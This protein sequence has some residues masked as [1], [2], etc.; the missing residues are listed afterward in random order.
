MDFSN[1]YDLSV[2]F[3]QLRRSTNIDGLPTPAAT[4]RDSH[5]QLSSPGPGPSSSSSR[6]PFA[7]PSPPLPVDP[8]AS[9]PPL[10]NAYPL[11]SSSSPAG[12]FQTVNVSPR[13]YSND[14]RA[15]RSPPPANP[16]LQRQM[17]ESPTSYGNN[18]NEYTEGFRL[19]PPSP[20]SS[21][22]QPQ[23]VDTQQREAAPSPASEQD[24]RPSWDNRQW[25]RD[26]R[27][28]QPDAGTPPRREMQ[29][30]P[31][32]NQTK[33]STGPS[34]R[35]RDDAQWAKSWRSP[36]EQVWP[37]PAPPRARAEV[38]V[39]GS[40][41]APAQQPTV[42]AAPPPVQQQQAQPQVEEVCVECAM[43]DEDMADVDVTSP[44]VWAR[45]SDV[46]FEDLLQK[47][48]AE[49]EAGIVSG[50]PSRPRARGGRLTEANLRLWLTLVR[51]P[52]FLGLRSV[53]DGAAQ[54][55][56]EPTSKRANL[57]AYVRSQYAL[58]EA[59]AIA[60]TRAI[61]EARQLDD[62]MRDTYSA[63]R[64]STYDLNVHVP[65]NGVR[66][67][68]SGHGRD[69][70]LLEN[71]L[72]VEH[73]DV[74]REERARRREEKRARGRSRK[75]SRGSAADV[76]SVYSL[77]SPLMYGESAAQAARSSSS[78][79][80]S[81]LTAPIMGESMSL[82]GSQSMI[83][84][85]A[86]MPQSRSTMSI[87]SPN[88]RT[89][90]FGSR[91]LSQGFRS[92][93]S[94]AAHSGFS[95]SMIDMHVAL[96]REKYSQTARPSSLWHDYATPQPLEPQ[97]ALA[98]PVDEKPK[99]KKKGLAK[100]WG[101]V[102]GTSKSQTAPSESNPQMRSIDREDDYPLAP[103][104][105]MSYL[106]NRGSQR[107]GGQRHVSTPSLPVSSPA[108]G[109]IGY[110]SSSTGV[111]PPSAPSSILPSPTSS[112]PLAGSDPIHIR[113]GSGANTHESEQ[114]IGGVYAQQVVPAVLK[115]VGE[116]TSVPTPTTRGVS[117]AHMT[118]EPDMR[119]RL[120][121]ADA[122]PV[123]RIPATIGARPISWRDK[124]L[125]PLPGEMGIGG[126]GRPRTLFATP[127]F[128]GLGPPSGF[129]QDAAGRR[130]SFSG[131]A[132]L[133][134]MS[135]G[136]PD[137][138][139]LSTMLAPPQTPTASSKRKSKFGFGA[140]LGRGRGG[141]TSHD[142]HSAPAPVMQFRTS[143]SDARHEAIVGMG[144]VSGMGN[145]QAHAFPRMS[146]SLTSRKNI[147]TLVEQ[148]PDFVAYRYPSGVP[149]GAMR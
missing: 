68:A 27:P 133:Q 148:A 36:E 147:E 13:R 45:E 130:Q 71:G 17:T 86:G 19:F 121:V 7:K 123:P 145:T 126:E 108:N 129:R 44:G 22:P 116:E 55:P 120:S 21:L 12:A 35:A 111:S 25:F 92:S 62:R 49:E 30:Q 58:L 1:D 98:I 4:Q 106:A 60:R 105:P 64:R 144:L 83:G 3:D 72:I 128:D 5:G 6:P 31:K 54:N 95:G 10:S 67:E 57:E 137:T 66:L 149:A 107:D 134:P 41:R 24:G 61:Q 34:V 125:P 56:K 84:L 88:R 142:S 132:S 139:Q 87:E 127:T 103:P 119:A 138:R 53:D 77:G 91:N 42:V 112:R 135:Y 136:Q 115:P 73:V 99:K 93:D 110:G 63:L 140:L 15:S 143:G 113:K 141:S 14:R 89:R 23:T 11:G 37:E 2:P 146:M 26:Q 124:S 80:M 101:I 109:G 20:A 82:S 29:A 81:V 65:D 118:S 100:L 97:R 70:T 51:I 96:Q 8:E 33:D 59:E 117:L 85:G 114:M 43:R 79:P 78:R 94:L 74:R 38:R 48:E 104:P 39:S 32:H 131:I 76:A 52:P 122:P 75:S 9:S 69:V 18:A 28:E 90:F 47:E 16:D 50:D 46:A 102:T 40:A